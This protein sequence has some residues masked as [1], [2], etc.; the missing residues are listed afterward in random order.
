MRSEKIDYQIIGKSMQLV[1]VTLDQ[2]ETL[3]AVAGAINYMENGIAFETKM[4]DGSEANQGL[5]GKLF[6]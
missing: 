4:G 1:E 5:M 3:V 6:I 2:G